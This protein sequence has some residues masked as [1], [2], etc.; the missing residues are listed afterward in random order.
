MPWYYKRRG[1]HGKQSTSE[2]TSAYK[3]RQK[4]RREQRD[5][6][7][8][9]REEDTSE[10]ER[11]EAA[12]KAKVRAEV[13]ARI[14]ER[15]RQELERFAQTRADNDHAAQVTRRRCADMEEFSRLNAL[16]YERE[17][18]ERRQRSVRSFRPACTPE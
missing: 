10:I 9:Q 6:A 13:L 14:A 17:Q 12:R 3:Q 16:R 18:E 1:A 11:I 7:K 2:V 4:E 15:T 5:E 8:A